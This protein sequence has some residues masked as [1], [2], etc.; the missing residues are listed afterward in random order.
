MCF[1]SKSYLIKNYDKTSLPCTAYIS[2]AK[3]TSP[4]PNG[5]SDWPG[6]VPWLYYGLLDNS[7]TSQTIL[8]SPISRIISTYPNSIISNVS[9]LKITKKLSFYVASFLLNGTLLGFTLLSNELQLCPITNGKMY[10]NRLVNFQNVGSGYSVECLFDLKRFFNNSGTIFY[11]MYLVDDQ[12]NYRP[13]PVNIRNYVSS[14][15]VN[16]NFPPAQLTRR[17]FIIDMVSGQLSS[18]GLPVVFRVAQEIILNIPLMSDGNILTPYLD[19]LYLERKTSLVLNDLSLS[20]SSIANLKFSVK[21]TQSLEDFN[22]FWISIYYSW[23]FFL[24]IFCFLWL[25]ECRK[26]YLLSVAIFDPVQFWNLI[27][28]F[29]LSLKWTSLFLFW[30][31][32]FVSGYFFFGFKFQSIFLI[33]VPSDSVTIYYL[34]SFCVIS[35]FCSLLYSFF[36]VYG[37]INQEVFLI[38]WEKSKIASGSEKTVPISMWRIL[39]LTRKIFELQN[40]RQVNILF[41]LVGLLVFM[42]A[43][44]LRNLAIPIA[45]RNL[46]VLGETN[47]ILLFALDSIAW[48]V[49]IFI[50]LIWNRIRTRFNGDQI[51]DL[52]DVLSLSNISV[53]IF[54]FPFHGYYI[55]GR[56][57]HPCADTNFNEMQNYLKQEES[58]LLPKRGLNGLEKQTF[59]IYTT[60]LFRK[61]LDKFKGI[62]DPQEEGNYLKESSL[63]GADRMY[64]LKFLSNFVENNLKDFKFTIRI[65]TLW[66]K[67]FSTIPDR[68]SSTL[69]HGI[70]SLLY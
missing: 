17:F 11:E 46:E 15:F 3:S 66:E 37:Q 39:C 35:L 60:D 27:S 58:N 63:Y 56:S 44:N 70:G 13:I 67:H 40:H 68:N 48:M 12:G 14:G 26:H 22:S 24:V 33:I 64:C 1:A 21:Y 57:I 38:D 10:N 5:I 25:Q 62:Q 32:F 65:P 69:L 41:C 28:F 45:S 43:L 20:N 16:E 51:S 55:H 7:F 30:F 9:L 50:Q 49:L 61:T 8:Q 53:F 2:I 59:Q 31:N 19:I 34:K 6:N 52:L 18:G 36:L 23:F 47:P 4:P 54:D 29:M 42:A